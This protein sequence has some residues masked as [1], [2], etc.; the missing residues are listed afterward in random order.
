MTLTP[1]G[2]EYTRPLVAQVEIKAYLSKATQTLPLLPPQRQQSWV[3]Q[4]LQQ[5]KDGI[6]G[7]RGTF[8]QDGVMGK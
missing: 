2:P 4:W 8:W 6:S 3:Y 5:E 1:V 7:D